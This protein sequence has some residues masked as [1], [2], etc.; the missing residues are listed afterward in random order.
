MKKYSLL[1]I[2]LLAF[3]IA[4]EA[5]KK[6]I[7]DAIEELNPLKVGRITR[8]LLV[9]L[10]D[11]N[12]RD[13]ITFTDHVLEEQKKNLSFSNSWRD[14]AKIALGGGLVAGALYY[15]KFVVESEKHISLRGARH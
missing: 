15:A 7:Y 10:S 4:V 6:E 5:K 12:I 11:K 8:R 3:T 1:V 9:D 13:I 2:S 14:C